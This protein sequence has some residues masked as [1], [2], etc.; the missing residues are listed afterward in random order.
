MSNAIFR[1][2][3]TWGGDNTYLIANWGTKD[4]IWGGYFLDMSNR[5]QLGEVYMMINPS[6]DIYLDITPH[7][8][9]KLDNNPSG[10]IYEV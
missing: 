3:A 1:R 7:T 8:D 10:E 2:P 4:L 6:A 5:R 9:V